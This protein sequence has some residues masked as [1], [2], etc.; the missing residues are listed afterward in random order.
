MRGL[1][2]P[3]GDKGDGHHPKALLE[4]FDDIGARHIFR[5]RWE[6]I[7]RIQTEFLEEGWCGTPQKRLARAR[8]ATDLINV[9]ARL[10]RAQD[11]VGIYSPNRC[12]LRSGND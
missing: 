5:Q 10:Q 3:N 11:P 7:D 8:V 9:T 6:L 12:D 4:C 1:G 2:H